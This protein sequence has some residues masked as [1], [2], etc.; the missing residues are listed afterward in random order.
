[1]ERD[2]FDGFALYYDISWS[3]DEWMG[4]V[5]GYSPNIITIFVFIFLV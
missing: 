4:R 2:G 5:V 1:M 3:K